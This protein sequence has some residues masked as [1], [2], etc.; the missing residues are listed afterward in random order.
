MPHP[1]LSDGIFIALFGMLS[2]S[3]PTF[4]ITFAPANERLEDYQRPRVRVYQDTARAI[5]RHREASAVP[6]PLTHQAIGIGIGGIPRGAAHAV[7]AFPRCL[8]PDERG[9]IILVAKGNIHLRQRG[10]GIESRHPHARHRARPFL[11]C[12]GE[13]THFG[14]LT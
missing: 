9:I 8:P 7:P 12:L 14:H 3:I 2:S 1:S 5:A 4:L 13:H 10:G 11:A 6:T